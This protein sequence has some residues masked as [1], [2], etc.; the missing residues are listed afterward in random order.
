[1]IAL[2]DNPD[3]LSQGLSSTP[4]SEDNTFISKPL[5]QPCEIRCLFILPGDWTVLPREGIKETHSGF[6]VSALS[7]GLMTLPA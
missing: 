1:M 2:H 4:K 7:S 6:G 3:C 5:L